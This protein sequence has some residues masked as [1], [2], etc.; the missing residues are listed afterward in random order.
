MREEY[1]SAGLAHVKTVMVEYR[2][3]IHWNIYFRR[4][5]V[6]VPLVI[7]G[8]QSWPFPAI[9]L[10]RTN[11]IYSG[12]KWVTIFLSAIYTVRPGQSC[13]CCLGLIIFLGIS[14]GRDRNYLALSPGHRL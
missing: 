5:V 14:G 7:L 10:L 9:L 8:T 12:T 3:Q 13:P 2:E 6:G 4:S 1:Y 11:A